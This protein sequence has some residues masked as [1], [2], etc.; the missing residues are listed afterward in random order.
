[1]AG[2]RTGP[3]LDPTRRIANGYKYVTR[4]G[5]SLLAVGAEGL[6]SEPPLFLQLTPWLSAVVL[7]AS[8]EGKI[9]KRRVT[10]V[11]RAI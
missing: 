8:P 9:L 10:W 6:Q 5:E 4:E 1:M 11:S 3:E 7:C 2:N